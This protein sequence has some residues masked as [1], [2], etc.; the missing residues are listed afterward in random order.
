MWQKARII[1]P[2]P[3]FGREFYVKDEPVN[4][5][6]VLLLDWDEQH[7]R[8]SSS[9]QK[10]DATNVLQTNTMW[11]GKRNYI[12]A[13]DVELLPEFAEEVEMEEWS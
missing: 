4:K 11:H 2:S 12:S 1:K 6:N 10:E 8:L 9:G 7:H 5:N 3:L 13:E